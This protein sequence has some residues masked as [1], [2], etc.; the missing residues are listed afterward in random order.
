M[1]GRKE[2]PV[3]LLDRRFWEDIIQ[4]YPPA[5]LSDVFGW[6]RGEEFEWPEVGRWNGC[7]VVIWV[8]ENEKPN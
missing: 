5:E 2:G 8:A 4:S 1:T 7:L 6:G 3:M